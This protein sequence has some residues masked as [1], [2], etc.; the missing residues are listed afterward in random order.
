MIRAYHPKDKEKVLKLIRLNTPRYFA[1]VEEHDLALYLDSD[2]DHY[3]L[4]EENDE[5]IAAGGLNPFPEEN[6]V[7]LSWDL[8]H[9][10]FHGKGIGRQLI[11]Y[12]IGEIQKL[13]EVKE[14]QVR[15][16]QL[17][18]GFYEKMG[19]T[20]TRIVKDFWASGF[21]LYDM[22]LLLS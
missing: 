18:C 11:R 6:L 12:R 19:F 1:P 16:T 17:V 15:T 8:V 20:T 2:A 21:H 10:D 4:V 5:V 9:P 22:R 7:R 3:F 14:I 13:F